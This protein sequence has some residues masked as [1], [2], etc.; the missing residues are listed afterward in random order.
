[1]K[2]EARFCESVEAAENGE[3]KAVVDHVALPDQLAV[4][5]DLLDIA[6]HRAGEQRV[7]KPLPSDGQRRVPGG[8]EDRVAAAGRISARNAHA[9]LVAAFGNNGS[10]GERFAEVG[11][12]LT[13]PAVVADSGDGGERLWF[14]VMMF[15]EPMWIM[16]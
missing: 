3:P 11:H 8:G 15:H 9:R 10:V 12:P 7:G 5:V 4:L 2:R 6:L 16:K 13:G 14:E 1:M